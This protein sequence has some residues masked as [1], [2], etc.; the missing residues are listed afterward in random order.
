MKK[1]FSLAG[2]LVFFLASFLPADTERPLVLISPL[3]IEGLSADEGRIIENLIYSYINNLGEAFI[4]PESSDNFTADLQD[5]W[6][7]D[8]IFSGTITQNEDGFILA[9][10]IGGTATGERASFSS[11]YK[12]TGDL[13]LNVRSMVES[14]FAGRIPSTV[15]GPDADETEGTAYPSAETGGE[16]LAEENIMGTWRGEPGIALIRL[17]RGG[18]GIAV[19]SSG[20]QMNLLYSIENNILTVVQNSPN[21]EGYYQR[22]GSSSLTIP[23]LVTRRLAGEAKPM[24]WELLLYENGTVLRGI[25]TVSVIRHDLERILEITHGTIQEVEWIRTGR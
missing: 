11:V 5:R 20:A 9:I 8:Y 3:A 14:A 4:P 10:E 19:F 23:Y 24:R 12:T 18:Q 16:P 2:V 7:P 13:V 6:I 25:K 22:Q 1:K 17:R 15:S 21:T